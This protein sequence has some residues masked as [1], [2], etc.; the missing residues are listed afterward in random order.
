MLNKF[1]DPDQLHNLIDCFLFQGLTLSK[2][3][4]HVVCNFLSTPA[5]KQT[6]QARQKHSLVGGGNVDYMTVAAVVEPG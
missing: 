1:S 5:K 2:C 3:C 6:N 4:E